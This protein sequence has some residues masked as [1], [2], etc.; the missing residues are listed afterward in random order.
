MWV[1]FSQS[2]NFLRKTAPRK[3]YVILSI[4]NTSSGEISSKNYTQTKKKTV[5]VIMYSEI[6][7]LDEFGSACG[8][9]DKEI[10]LHIRRL[11]QITAY[12]TLRQKRQRNISRQ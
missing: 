7:I 3:S 8:R 2:G 1:V 4:N 12:H 6:I 5:V 11:H 9:L 10:V